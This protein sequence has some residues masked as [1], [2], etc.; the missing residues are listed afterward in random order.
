VD[1]R[2]ES[3]GVELGI[4]M[5][6]RAWRYEAGGGLF[7]RAGGVMDRIMEGSDFIFSLRGIRWHVMNSLPIT[8]FLEQCL[9]VFGLLLVYLEL[10]TEYLGSQVFLVVTY[11]GLFLFVAPSS[12]SSPSPRVPFPTLPLPLKSY[13]SRSTSYAQHLSCQ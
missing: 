5:R 12:L 1:A 4:G 7:F 10:A 6:W 3:V 11:F 9:G 13:F 8:D 2:G